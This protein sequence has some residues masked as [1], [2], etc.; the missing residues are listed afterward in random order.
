[1]RHGAI[2]SA[3]GS[4]LLEVLIAL[5]LLAVTML[6]AL[7]GQWWAS[8]GE[9]LAGQRAHAVAIAASVAEAM[10]GPVAPALARWQARAA[11]SLPNADVFVSDEAQ[12]ISQAI[13]RWAMPRSS[14]GNEAMV[15][16][17]AGLACPHSAMRSGHACVAV[18][19][20]PP[21]PLER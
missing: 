12:G 6:G 16:Q 7:A 15:G 19:F 9:R 1:M 13:V 10:H 3:P 17:P 20:V 18:P 8:G 21:A 4:S 11:A 2:R 14:E 5:A